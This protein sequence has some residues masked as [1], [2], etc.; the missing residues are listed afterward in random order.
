MSIL[1]TR[2]RPLA[3][4]LRTDLI[5]LWLSG[6]NP[7]LLILEQNSQLFAIKQ[8]SGSYRLAYRMTRTAS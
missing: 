6:L 1:G 7:V 4:A 3:Y 8:V 5:P 2:G